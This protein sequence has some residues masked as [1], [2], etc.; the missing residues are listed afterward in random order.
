MPVSAALGVKRRLQPCHGRAELDGHI[1][2]Y[3]IL[4]DA[5]AILHQLGRQMAISQ[6]PGHTDQMRQIIAADIGN[7]LVP[8]TYSNRRSI[9]QQQDVPIPQ[10]FQLWQ[11]K[12]EGCSAICLQLQ[13]PPAAMIKIQC[14]RITDHA[15]IWR[16]GCM[17]DLSMFHGLIHEIALGHG[18]FRCRIAG[19]QF[20]IRMNQIGFRINIDFRR[21][22]V[23]DHRRLANA[24]AG[25]FNR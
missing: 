7:R 24:G 2:N 22:A 25:I 15:V 9:F 10:C 4:A 23:M 13:P 3:M 17:N 16:L 18:E 14:D 12:K 19:E 6:M 8:G 5:Q 20:P 1:L 21:C 11:V